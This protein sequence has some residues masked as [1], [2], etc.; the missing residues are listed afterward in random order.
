MRCHPY[1]QRKLETVDVADIRSKHLRIRSVQRWFY[2]CGFFTF[3]MFVMAQLSAAERFGLVGDK[4]PFV[5]M[6]ESH[7]YH[8][9]VNET[10]LE[11][12]GTHFWEK[13]FEPISDL[14]AAKIPE[15]DVW[16]FSQET[17]VTAYYDPQTVHE[18]P[19]S[20]YDIGTQEWMDMERRK[21]APL[22]EKFVQPKQSLLKE[23]KDYYY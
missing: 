5:Y 12:G 7:H 2:G 13:W 22:M 19:Y 1:P 8:N 23:A 21:A 14:D 11:K 4:K 16:E 20:P 6:P 17:I 15:E 10:E 18:Y 9:C 3:P